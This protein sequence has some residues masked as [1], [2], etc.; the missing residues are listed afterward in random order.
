MDFVITPIFLFD[1]F[2][3]LTTASSPRRYFFRGWGW[4][5]LLSC[6]P[7]LRVF[8]VFRVV[9]V[10]RLLRAYGRTGSSPT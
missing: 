2:Y 7:L 6:V 9:R 10:I 8:R 4:A 3:R 5:D 1:F